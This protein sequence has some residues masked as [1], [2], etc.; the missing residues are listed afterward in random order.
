MEHKQSVQVKVQAVD[1]PEASDVKVRWLLGPESGAPNFHMRQFHVAPGGHTPRH[2]HAWEHECY[3]LSG[4]GKA[5]SGE[6]GDR[7][8]QPGDVLLIPGGEEHQFL[9]DGDEELVFLCMIPV[10][11][12]A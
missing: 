5:F 9:N 4:K 6:G 12:D 3:I 7:P 8:V 11:K 2:S 1:D 10:P